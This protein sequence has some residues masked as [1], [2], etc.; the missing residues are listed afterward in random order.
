LL[1]TIGYVCI[2]AGFT[3][4]TIGLIT[5]FVYAKTIWGKFWSADPKEIWSIITWLLYAALLHGR[6]MIG[7]RG[8]IRCYGHNWVCSDSFHLSWR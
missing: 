1:D 8:A 2:L 3:L 4:M 5:G 7:W 6:L